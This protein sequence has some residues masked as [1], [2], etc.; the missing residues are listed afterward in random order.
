MNEIQNKEAMLREYLNV[1]GYDAVLIYRR[2][3]FSWITGG[4]IGHII[5]FTPYCMAV[6]LITKDDKF[7]IANQVE[8]V[9]F[10]EEELAALDYTLLEINWWEEDYVDCVQREF[11]DIK[12]CADKDIPEGD[13][14]WDDL[15]RLRYSLVPEEIERYR[16]LSAECVRLVE[17]TCKGIRPGQTEHSICGNMIGRALE[18]GIETPVALVASDERIYRYRHPIDTFK[19]INKY[20]MVVLCGQKFGL[21]ANL[22]R[23]V[24]FGKPSEEITSKFNLV[25]RIEAE[26]ITNTIVGTRISDIFRVIQNEYDSVGY[27]NEWMLL[28]QGGAAG[29]DTREY[30]ATPQSNESVYNHQAFTWNP[31][32][33]GTKAEDTI[34]VNKSGFEVLTYSHSWPQVKVSAKNGQVLHRPDL[35]IV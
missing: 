3:V 19:N 24:Y 13:N 16:E 4:K 33:T 27:K 26:I 15:K 2:D 6:L 21:V 30:I 14:V 11:G 28:H 17:E 32:I 8:K 7:C 31:S 10:M 20:A 34:L 1:K 25:R 12:L 29:Y 9:R 5:K 35:L 23:F 22:T 18:M